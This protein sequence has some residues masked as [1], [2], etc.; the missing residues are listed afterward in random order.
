MTSNRCSS[1]VLYPSHAKG[2][3][4]PIVLTA[5]IVYCSIVYDVK[6]DALRAKYG[7]MMVYYKIS[8]VFSSD[9]SANMPSKKKRPAPL[10]LSVVHQDE[11]TATLAATVSTMAY[12]PKKKKRGPYDPEVYYAV[13]QIRQE[14]E[15]KRVESEEEDEVLRPITK[16]RKREPPQEAVDMLEQLDK[17]AAKLDQAIQQMK[18]IDPPV[19]AVSEGEKLVDDE[20]DVEHLRIC[21]FHMEIIVTT[22][23][24]EGVKVL[25]CARQPCVI[26]EFSEE[27]KN[28]YL[29][30]L[31]RKVH[32]SL[33]TKT[34]E[35]KC[36]CGLLPGLRQSKSGN[37]PDRM[38]LA[39]RQHQC[40]FFRW[41]D[42]P[43]ADPA[44]TLTCPRHLEKMEERV[45]KSG[46]EY[47]RCPS[48][49]RCLL[50]CDK[51][52]GEKYMTAVR[53]N[54]HP[55]ICDR[56]DKVTCL[57]GEV[58]LIKQSAS[59]KNPDR[60]Y[61]ACGEKRC[62]FFRWTDLPVDKENF[63]DPLA[64]QDWLNVIPD[65]PTP[66]LGESNNGKELPKRYGEGLAQANQR[67]QE[68]RL[69]REKIPPMFQEVVEVDPPV[70]VDCYQ[71]NF[72][73]DYVPLHPGVI[74]NAKLG[75]F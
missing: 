71:K 29:K 47:L 24:R 31:Y 48:I 63:K 67:R 26:A 52:K 30:G 18:P 34:D 66:D 5:S 4:K 60:L 58:P 17:D 25:R 62:K 55:D 42:L 54:I 46:W 9:H 38:Y 8:S 64:V 57:C 19:K 14:E 20:E 44:D 28:S 53:Q 15:K 69:G 12:Q 36:D 75:L 23:T 56:W 1:I 22:D 10:D 40:K 3:S 21:P 70:F 33:Y 65:S 27:N 50:L 13:E 6:T 45:A 51:F 2:K 41:A 39:C 32:K 16:R 43:I 72:K 74:E 59:A 7:G 61:L 68:T 37:N 35:L 49:H 73:K 11:S